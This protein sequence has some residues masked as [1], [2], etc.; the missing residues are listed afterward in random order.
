[1]KSENQIHQN[2][3][4]FPGSDNKAVDEQTKEFARL[5]DYISHAEKGTPDLE[6]IE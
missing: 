6:F 3:I 4:K 2:I 5:I 1:M